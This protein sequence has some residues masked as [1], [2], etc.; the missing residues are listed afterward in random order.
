MGD[1]MIENRFRYIYIECGYKH[2][3]AK[4]VR[5]EI[6]VS[7]A[8]MS[9]LMNRDNYKPDLETAIRAA[10]FFKRPVEEIWILM[11]E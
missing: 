9:Q 2:G 8:T 11:E 7:A 5:D 4:K 1:W 10:R 3:D 6:G